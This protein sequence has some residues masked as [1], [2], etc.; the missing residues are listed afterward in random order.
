MALD[1]RAQDTS[2]HARL[3]GRRGP[4]S[5]QEH[6]PGALLSP[7]PC[8]R[9]MRLKVCRRL[10]HLWPRPLE[11]VLAYA[12][13]SARWRD[14]VLT[15]A[16]IARWGS[17]LVASGLR[18]AGHAVRVA[19]REPDRWLRQALACRDASCAAEA[20]LHRTRLRAA[21]EQAIF[22]ATRSPRASGAI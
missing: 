5:T 6:L 13:R 1:M 10:S 20:A 16:Q 9:S 15:A 8:A 14:V 18:L 7:D 17:A 22:R 4:N 12:L 19:S 11:D 21:L 3:R 2:A